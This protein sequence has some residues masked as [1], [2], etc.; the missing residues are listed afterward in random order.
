MFGSHVYI[1][2]CIN[3]AGIAL[4]L[5]INFSCRKQPPSQSY[6]AMC[7]IGAARARHSRKSLFSDSPRKIGGNEY[8]LLA[9][10]PIQPLTALA[11]FASFSAWRT[12]V[13]TRSRPL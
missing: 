7:T 4:L 6:I 9:Q 3:Y 12:Y 8:V 10:L 1:L 2:P 11:L 13:H 5:P